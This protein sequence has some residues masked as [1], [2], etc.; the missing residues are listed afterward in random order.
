M[1]PLW[2]WN[3]QG[4]IKKRGVRCRPYTGYPGLSFQVFLLKILELFFLQRPRRFRKDINWPEDTSE[5]CV[6]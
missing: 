5:L 1:L 6:R 3:F 2:I 4:S